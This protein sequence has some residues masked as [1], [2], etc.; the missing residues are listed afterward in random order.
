M[1][2]L[3]LFSGIGGFEY[4]IHSIWPQAVC[5]GYSEIKPTA[6]KVYK[7]HFP[8]H[9]ELGDIRNI[10]PEEIPN[11]NLCDLI[12][13]GFPCTN[14]SSLAHIR[15]DPRGLQGSASGLFY[16]LLRIIAATVAVN[17]NVHIL[18]ENNA[19]MNKANKT[20]ITEELSFALG[21][22]VVMNALDASMFGVQTRK[23][24]YWTSFYVGLPIECK[25]TWNDI[26][27]PFETVQNLKLSQRYI[28]CMNRLIPSPSI[29]PTRVFFDGKEFQTL[30][31]NESSR[32]RWQCCFH[33]DTSNVEI[34]HYSYPI[35]KSR[36]ITASFGNHNV[37]VDRRGNGPLLIRLWSLHEIER[38]FALPVG[39]VSSPELGLT[40]RQAIECLGNCVVVTVIQYILSN[41]LVK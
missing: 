3:S 33:S 19:S 11:L 5:L 39:W 7:S 9:R 38:A 41:Y 32:S 36:P 26:L 4:A 30:S 34:P 40:R 13:A 1:Y 12:V 16:E 2:Y 24:L 28:D 15:G 6:L 22:H 35:G 25:Q 10:K 21:K 14:L 8:T 17:P 31:H 29:Q 27:D 37:L 23:R 20:I 18:I